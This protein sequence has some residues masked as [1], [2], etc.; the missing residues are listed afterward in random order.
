LCLPLAWQAQAEDAHGQM[1]WAFGRLDN[2]VYYA[3][4]EGRE[5]RSASF[6]TLLDISAIAHHGAVCPIQ[7]LWAHRATRKRMLE[8]WRMAAFKIV[9]TTFLS[10]LDY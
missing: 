5:D 10:D 2:T 8:A 3:E 4:I 7:D 9:D 1:C 6:V